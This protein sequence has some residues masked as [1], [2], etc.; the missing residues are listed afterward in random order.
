[1]YLVSL[2]TPLESTTIINE[3]VIDRSIKVVQSGLLE[4][5]DQGWA[6]TVEDRDYIRG[7]RIFTS[8]LRTIYGSKLGF[9]AAFVLYGFFWVLSLSSLLMPTYPTAPMIVHFDGTS[10]LSLHNRFSEVSPCLSIYKGM[11]GGS[12]F[13]L[14]NDLDVCKFWNCSCVTATE[15]CS[16]SS[17]CRYLQAIQVASHWHA[18][19]IGCRRRRL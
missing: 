12:P 6:A 3:S 15:Q 7:R 10:I 19:G 9:T 2:W 4:E 8:L 13:R 1:V 11:P 17:L 5:R 14:E 18:G 16:H